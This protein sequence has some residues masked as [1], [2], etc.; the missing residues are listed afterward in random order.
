MP[1]STPYNRAIPVAL[2]HGQCT[3]KCVSWPPGKRVGIQ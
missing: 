2:P 3:P 1:L